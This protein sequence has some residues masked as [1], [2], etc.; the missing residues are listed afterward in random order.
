M[1]QLKSVRGAEKCISNTDIWKWKCRSALPKASQLCG[2]KVMLGST[3]AT[4]IAGIWGCASS[5]AFLSLFPRAAPVPAAPS[6][7]C[8]AKGFGWRGTI[9]SLILES[10]WLAGNGMAEVMNSNEER[11]ECWQIHFKPDWARNQDMQCRELL[12]QRACRNHW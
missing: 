5:A 1:N 11:E 9:G 8:Q 12:L 6:C 2:H 10:A 4:A 3:M 7:C